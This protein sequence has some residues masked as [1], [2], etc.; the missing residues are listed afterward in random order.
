MTENKGKEKCKST[1]N[2]F[3]EFLGPFPCV[4]NDVTGDMNFTVKLTKKLY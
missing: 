3:K 4:Q 1:N 2:V